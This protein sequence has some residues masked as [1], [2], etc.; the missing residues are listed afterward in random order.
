ML[1]ANWS[2]GR[3][4]VWAES[5]RRFL[6]L[7]DSQANPLAPASEEVTEHPFATPP[8]ELRELLEEQIPAV[9]NLLG[10]ET[11]LVITLPR[12]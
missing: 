6:L 3:L 9:R 12:D 5:I 4:V 2:D 11:S 7:S 1:H 8:D 10:E